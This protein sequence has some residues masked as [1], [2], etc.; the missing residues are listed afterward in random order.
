MELGIE[1]SGWSSLT[2]S[3]FWLHLGR[4]LP[5][6]AYHVLFIPGFPGVWE[7]ENNEFSTEKCSR[8]RLPVFKPSTHSTFSSVTLIYC[9]FLMN[10][11]HAHTEVSFQSCALE[12][13][14]SQPVEH[15]TRFSSIQFQRS[16]SLQYWEPSMVSW[17]PLIA[18]ENTVTVLC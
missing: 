18:K 15:L 16:F 10:S 7:R 9:P 6:W 12:T 3:Q 11:P 1:K 4:A 8:E 5:M 14:Y 17:S 2:S 13:L